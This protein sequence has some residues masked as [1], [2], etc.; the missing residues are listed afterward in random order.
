MA[1]VE[2]GK[3]IDLLR[4]PSSAL[5]L[6]PQKDWMYGAIGAIVGVIGFFFWIWCFQEAIKQ[7]LFSV[8]GNLFLYSILGMATPGKYFLIGLFSVVLLVGTLTVLGNWQGAR[9]RNWM[10]VVTLQGSSQLLFGAVWIV[11]G[12]LAFMSL[13]LSMLL[14]AAALLINLLLLVAQAQD[15]HEVSRER[16]FLY[17]VY[18]MGI[19]MLLLFFVYSIIV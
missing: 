10:E 6:Q 1:G 8:L 19:Y 18:A 5:N 9:K 12:L 13:Q 14:G 17:I 3:L 15:F 11:S 4:N 16:R 2:S 7:K